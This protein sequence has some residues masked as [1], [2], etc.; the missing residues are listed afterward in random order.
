MSGSPAKTVAKRY[1]AFERSPWLW[2]P[3]QEDRGLND[4][5]DLNLNE[6]SIP[7]VLTPESPAAVSTIA[8]SIG[9]GQR[10]K[11][12]SL[13]LTLRQAPNQILHF[14]SLSLL[15]S[16]IEVFFVQESFRVDSLIHTGT[17]DIAKAL[18]HLLVAI[19]SAGSMSISYSSIWKMGLA[20]QE[21]VRNTLGNFVRSPVL[22]HSSC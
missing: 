14:P 19:V 9:Q 21:V 16:I 22:M 2:K 5:I 8:P 17:F 6:D 3:T 1:A 18:P 7:S 15:N 12:L 20:L 13:L 4:Q 10:D 11:M